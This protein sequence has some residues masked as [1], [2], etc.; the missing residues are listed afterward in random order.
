MNRRLALWIVLAAVV[1]PRFARAQQSGTGEVTIGYQGLPHK[2]SGENQTGIQ[3]SDGVLMHVGAGAEGGYDSN[4]FY[5]ESNPV[6]SQIYRATLFAGITNATRTGPAK[7]L[8]FDARAGLQYRRYQSADV[9]IVQNDFQNAWMPTA[10]LALSA[11]TGQ[12]GFG[13]A[14]TFARIEEPPYQQNQP[15]IIRNNNQ[16]SV[17]GR[18]SPGGGR[19]TGLLRYTN[20]IDVFSQTSGYNYANSATN[21]FMLDASWKWLP[22]T[23]IFVNAQQGYIF[24]L[25]ETAASANGKAPAYPLRVVTGLR[26]LLTEKTSA[27]L[28]LGYNNSFSGITSTGGFWGSSFV[29][30]AFTLRPTELSRIVAGYR[31]DFQNSI[32][33]TFYYADTVYASY[34]Q[35][36]G[37]RVGLDLSGRYVRKDYEG[38]LPN[39]GTSARLDNFFQVGATLDYFIRNWM[40]A[41]LGYALLINDATL[42]PNPASPTPPAPDSANYTKHQMFVR[43]GLTY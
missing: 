16:A 5:S 38:L 37:G 20:M 39:T 2:P 11:G 41:G 34:V 29:E 13:L 6:G 43:L 1:A 8:S 31:H 24:Y 42:T 15:V 30:L 18:W 35:Q 14:D 22:K 40:Y 19:L 17:E 3:V 32:I 33:S 26:G 4:V 7:T 21:L 12:L 9:A 36:I 10:G 23:A 28:S 25:D 27:V